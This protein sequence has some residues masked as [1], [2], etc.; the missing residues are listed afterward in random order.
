MIFSANRNDHARGITDFPFYPCWG[1]DAD[2]NDIGPAVLVDTETGRAEFYQFDDQGYVISDWIKGEA[3][4][5][6]VY[7]KPPITL[8]PLSRVATWRTQAPLL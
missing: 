2:G 4:R 8:E 1:Y 5:K 6:V 7:F 3:L